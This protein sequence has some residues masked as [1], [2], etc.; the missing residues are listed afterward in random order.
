MRPI[1][2]E[3]EGFSAF[4]YSAVVDLEGLD[5]VGFTGQTGSGKSSLID[6]ITFALY[7][8][9]ARYGSASA[10]A[11]AIHQLAE[12]AKVRLD[13]EVAG[14]R[15]V[16]VRI[17]RR[18]TLKDP[19]AS[20]QAST[21]EARL[22]T[23]S[24]E[25][26]AGSVKEL[27][28]AVVDL[29]GLDFAQF[30]R[31]IV[32]PQGDFADFLNDE[33][34]NRQKL[35]RR[36]LDMEIYGKM[37]TKARAEEELDKQQ[38]TTLM[39][40]QERNPAPTD[41]EFAE[42]EARQAALVSAHPTIES[43]LAEMKT[44]VTQRQDLLDEHKVASQAA[45]RLGSVEVP[46]AISSA[47]QKLREVKKVQAEAH[48]LLADASQSVNETTK[49]PQADLAELSLAIDRLERLISLRAEGAVV[50]TTET[51]L[52]AN[53]T[54]IQ[55]EQQPLA[56]SR[57]DAQGDYER[58]QV[59]A[60]ASDW[61]ESLSEGEPCPLC[62]Q[63]VTAIPDH[64]PDQ[65][66]EALKRS[67][68]EAASAYK[69]WE[70]R[71]TE[72]K[73]ELKAIGQSI[74]TR[75]GALA[76]LEAQLMNSD[77]ELF[78]GPTADESDLRSQV[79]RLRVKREEAVGVA[80][81]IKEARFAV[82]EAQTRAAKADGQ[83]RS[84]ES[85]IARE[86]LQLSAVRDSLADLDPPPVSEES[87]LNNWQRLAKWAQQNRAIYEDQA[88]KVVDKGHQIAKELKR[89]EA[90]V[91][92]RAASLDLDV[93]E[94]GLDRLL[95]V[96]LVAQTKA[97]ADV[98]E[99]DRRRVE[100]QDRKKRISALNKASALNKSL[101][102]HLN[103][104]GFEGWLLNEALDNIVGKATD[105]LLQ[106]SGGQYSL[107]VTDR[108]FS[109]IDH[110]NA[111]ER[112]DVRT[113]SGGETFLASLA[114]ALA[115]ADSIAELAPVDAPRLESMFLDEGFGTL[116]PETLDVV[117]SAIEELAAD[118]RMIG[119]VTHVRDLAERLPV[120]FEVSKGPTT[121]TVE[122]VEL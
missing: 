49:Q 9:V 60:K 76:E 13:F 62:Q 70:T 110:N 111:D 53:L 117:A 20:P 100:A 96:L 120:R 41:T 73:A 72:Q 5:L 7:G 69:A 15:Y 36:L 34:A 40:E 12:E 42:L 46:E 108:Q 22:E 16:A 64:S 102:G 25:V 104:A 122:M 79:E 56:K 103:A 39:A 17:V 32:L 106:L 43:A 67:A 31:T 29:L 11:P 118:G 8:S 51:D 86:G 85:E 4:R 82:E 66:L 1:R 116:D 59:L 61:V 115:L 50:A 94:S 57:D 97:Q 75:A 47:D 99:A 35:L 33:P 58:A 24:G 121:S 10:V 14:A 37:G 81:S 71:Y 18:K 68:A 90:S 87:T 77:F 38:A 27:N 54:A 21:K 44:L 119:I 74:E 112:R 2:I 98:E 105:R 28:A 65:A 95:E 23:Q 55:G 92:E 48:A 88:S 45:S 84:V 19:N 93:A 114:L 107:L 113:L 101:G 26:L 80:E 91:A 3:V 63:T 6:A 83:L 52:A 78:V 30:T 109:I 89:K